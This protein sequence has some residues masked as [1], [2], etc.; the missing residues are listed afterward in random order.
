MKLFRVWSKQDKMYVGAI[1]DTEGRIQVFNQ[2]Y[3]EYEWVS[4]EDFVKH[5]DLERNSG[6]QDDFESDIYEGDI[7]KIMYGGETGWAYEVGYHGVDDYPAFEL[8]GWDGESNGLSEAKAVYK[9][10]VIGNI[11]HGVTKENKYEAD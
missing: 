1:L 9:I 5:Y 4:E 8:K 11:H 2:T 7:V 6:M 3:L 10:R